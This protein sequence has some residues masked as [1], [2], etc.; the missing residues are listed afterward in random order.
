[1]PYILL[2]WSWSSYHK[3]FS[4]KLYWDSQTNAYYRR[5]LAR[6]SA[7]INLLM[8]TW[9]LKIYKFKSN[10]PFSFCQQLLIAPS[11]F[12]RKSKAWKFVILKSS[13]LQRWGSARLLFTLESKVSFIRCNFLEW[14]DN[15]VARF[16]IPTA[17]VRKRTRD[18]IIPV[19]WNSC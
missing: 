13:L 7:S 2:F 15:L 6:P 10:V 5:L 4:S 19:V 14:L 9:T 17:G 3:N 16:G 18:S 1:M 12:D 8:F 11:I